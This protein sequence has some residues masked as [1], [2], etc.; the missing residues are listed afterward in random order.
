M[1]SLKSIV[2]FLLLLSSASPWCGPATALT[3]GILFSLLI[4]NP[5]PKASATWSKKLLQLSVVGL[6]FGVS[7]IEV[8]QA[9]KEAVLYTPISI[10]L[11]VAVGLFL[12]RLLSTPSRTSALIS[13]GTAIC[14]GSAIA[15]MAP[16]INA[17]DEEIAVSLATVFSLNAAALLLF[18]PLGHF[19]GLGQRQFGLWAAL[20]IHDTSSV[21]GAA[22]AFGAS[23][24]TIGTTVKLARAVWIAPSALIASRFT[25]TRTTTRIP[26]F[27]VGF[28][29]A[30]S[31]RSL[32][33]SMLHT[34]QVLATIARQG[35]VVTLFLVG[36]GLTRE[37]LR[38]VGVR[39]L[40]QGVILWVI[41]S[42]AMLAMI[43]N[44]IIQ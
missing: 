10:A 34:W 21:V 40:A 11:T 42:T 15:A 32:L 35:L 31:V 29:A 9:G 44:G 4:G 23:A 41:V 16:V 27:I 24:L 25:H 2:Y 30:A 43:I 20:A 33:P 8:W 12:G 5:W 6:G 19:F 17:D 3:L 28:I 39:P 26:L 38:R 37:V 36:N 22:S 13:F 1:F 7:I 18:P 14:G